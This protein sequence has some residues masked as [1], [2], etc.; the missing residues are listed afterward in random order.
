[1]TAQPL[2]D[3]DMELDELAK[4][5]DEDNVHVK[6][7]IAGNDGY[8]LAEPEEV[9]I[10]ASIVGTTIDLTG[11]AADQQVVSSSHTHGSL[12]ITSDTQHVPAVP[13]APSN[14]DQQSNRPPSE[15]LTP[16][17][18]PSSHIQVI[19]HNL[20]GAEPV[21]RPTR[22]PGSGPHATS[23]QFDC[24]YATK[25][26]RCTC[27]NNDSSGDSLEF[28]SYPISISITHTPDVAHDHQVS[29]PKSYTGTCKF[30]PGWSNV[31][32]AACNKFFV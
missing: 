14:I 28:L 27:W 16:P 10:P 13:S 12:D 18:A 5:R 22:N 17:K 30:H 15:P 20:S 3:V 11:A 2:D 25:F 26:T 1:M 8:L 6:V 31:K 9:V 7:E 23:S 29:F 21:F 19:D 32:H 24:G 4:D